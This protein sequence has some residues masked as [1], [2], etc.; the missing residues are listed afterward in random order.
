[1]ISDR[2]GSHARLVRGTLLGTSNIIQ[3]YP[4]VRAFLYPPPEDARGCQRV[5]ARCPRFTYC[6]IF[7]TY[8]EYFSCVGAE[9]WLGGGCLGGGE[10]STSLKLPTQRFHRNMNETS[11]SVLISFHVHILEG[12]SLPSPLPTPLTKCNID[13]SRFTRVRT[14]PIPD[15]HTVTQT[16]T[17]SHSSGLFIGIWNCIEK[18]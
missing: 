15:T 11:I 8:I 9:I 1:M 5:P 12:S 16:H 4:L 14:Y 2:G 18:C 7:G 6:I 13:S 17:H 10:V 3:C